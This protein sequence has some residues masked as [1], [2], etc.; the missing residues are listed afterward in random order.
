M[1][2]FAEP[3]AIYASDVAKTGGSAFSAF[4]LVAKNT[5]RCAT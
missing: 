5:R 2:Y 4:G 1:K 3:G